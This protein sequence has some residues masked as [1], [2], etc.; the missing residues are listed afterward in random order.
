[1]A[2]TFIENERRNLVSLVIRWCPY[3]SLVS[4]I[5]VHELAKQYQPVNIGQGCANFSPPS[6]LT[7][8]LKDVTQSDKWQLHQYSGSRVIGMFGTCSDYIIQVAFRA[9]LDW[10]RPLSSSTN[11]YWAD[12][13]VE[14]D[15]SDHRC[16]RS[17]I[18]CHFRTH[19]PW[20]WSDNHRTI[21]QCLRND[22]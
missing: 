6:S 10:H 8:A 21:L 12:R 2:G 16:H 4:R 20:W 17:L 1:M 18:L 9:T 13:F 11:H 3:Y 14:R 5:E 19:Q 15:T 7:Q 22:G